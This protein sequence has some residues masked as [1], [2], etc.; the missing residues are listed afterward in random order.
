MLVK[1]ID[2]KISLLIFFAVLYIFIKS[3]YIK[4]Q[5]NIS[6][7]SD[8]WN[9]W[10]FFQVSSSSSLPIIQYEPGFSIYTWVLSKFVGFDVYREIILVVIF[11]AM[12]FASYKFSGRF[13]SAVIAS[14]FGVNFYTPLSAISEVAIR[15]GL[16]ASILLFFLPKLVGSTLRLST[17]IIIFLLIVSFHYSAILLLVAFLLTYFIVSY[18]AFYIWLFF[19]FLYFVN[20]SGLV[21]IFL[22]NVLMINVDSLNDFN[23]LDI[24]YALGFKWGFF[25]LS[26]LPVT[27]AVFLSRVGFISLNFLDFIKSRLIIFY[28]FSNT[29]AMCFS[30]STFHDRFFI[31]S[32]I[33]IPVILFWLSGYFKGMNYS[34][35]E[36]FSRH[37]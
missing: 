34:R 4:N 12:V 32:W 36:Y 16:A 6:I 29:I 13:Y 22:Q 18:S 31:W 9:Y 28:F 20:F 11:I 35:H 27:I 1:R 3:L 15:Q 7:F 21:G 5:L 37:R 17:G 2:L 19:L 14:V 8:L 33:L 23:R 30:L 10:N 25:L 24:D 26:I